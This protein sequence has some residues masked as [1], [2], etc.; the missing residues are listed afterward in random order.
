[1]TLSH[2]HARLLKAEDA[3]R[4]TCLSRI[5]FVAKPP[6]CKLESIVL[7]VR[8]FIGSLRPIVIE[9]PLGS[10]G[11]FLSCLREGQRRKDF[12]YR[13]HL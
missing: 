5:T 1:M 10:A 2:C 11:E 7:L 9:Q 8:G 6:K 13:K 4:L 3:P 12:G